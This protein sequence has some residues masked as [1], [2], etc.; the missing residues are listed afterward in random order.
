MCERSHLRVL[1]GFWISQTA[2]LAYIPPQHCTSL[3]IS[4]R[5]PLHY[6]HELPRQLR[7]APRHAQLGHGVLRIV[8]EHA[9]RDIFE[10]LDR[11]RA[12][13]AHPYVQLDLIP[14]LVLLYLMCFN[15][16]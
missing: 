3:C 6:L 4:R 7:P 1:Y 9:V 15:K 14:H 8:R 16:E 2:N 10:W 12:D 11:G 5:G 13:R